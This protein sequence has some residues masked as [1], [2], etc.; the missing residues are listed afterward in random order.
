VTA[1]ASEPGLLARVAPAGRQAA[2]ARY[3]ARP[4]PAAWAATAQARGQVQDRLT[5]GPFAAGG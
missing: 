1:T 4:V 3:P 2:R 5:R